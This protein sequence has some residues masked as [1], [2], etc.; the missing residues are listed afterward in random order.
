MNCEFCSKETK[1]PRFCSKSCADAAQRKPRAPCLVCGKIADYEPKSKFCSRSCSAKFYNRTRQKFKA[2]ERCE[3]PHKNKRF[4]SYKCSTAHASEIQFGKVSEVERK[5]KARLS[6]LL[7]V[8]RYQAR[9]LN[10][11][12]ADADLEKI[13]EIYA[14]CPEGFEVDHKI[15]I[16]KGGLHHQDNLQ[17]LP[18]RENR[19]KS[20]K[21]DFPSDVQLLDE[22]ILVV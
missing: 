9:R 2:C 14:N 1:N 15:P 13:R 20:N 12:P 18:W 7:G 3:T 21:L 19:R 5:E 11:M 16:S 8:R 22:S 6:N 4:C 17:Y 10:Q